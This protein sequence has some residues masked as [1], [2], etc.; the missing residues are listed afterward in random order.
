[1]ISEYESKGYMY[2]VFIIVNLN[3]C[4]SSVPFKNICYSSLLYTLHLCF[5]IQGK[6]KNGPDIA[7]CR[8]S[9]HHTHQEFM[10]EVSILLQI[11]HENLIQL[12]GY[13]ID[14]KHTYLIY[15]CAPYATLS[16]LLFGKFLY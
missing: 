12:L 4:F 7:I 5:I 6:L 8:T 3:K 16:S 2:K 10:N 14:G 13:C 15:D 1:M 9:S 11:E